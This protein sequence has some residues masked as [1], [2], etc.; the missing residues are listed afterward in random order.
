MVAGTINTD[1]EAAFHSLYASS[2]EVSTLCLI[3]A[4]PVEEAQPTVPFAPTPTFDAMEYE[5]DTTGLQMRRKK[6]KK[7]IAPWRPFCIIFSGRQNRGL[8]HGPFAKP[9]YIQK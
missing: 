1:K 7:D 4:R 5:E 9:C 6:N 2:K 3:S 8:L